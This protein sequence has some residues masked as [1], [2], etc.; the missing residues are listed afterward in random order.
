MQ[1]RLQALKTALRGRGAQLEPC[2]DIHMVAHMQWVDARIPIL[3]VFCK[4]TCKYGLFTVLACSSMLLETTCNVARAIQQH[5]RT[6]KRRANLASEIERT[7][8]YKSV[9]KLVGSSKLFF[10]PNVWDLICFE[11]ST[12][13]VLKVARLQNSV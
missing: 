6:K 1:R 11:S 7:Q 2:A 5:T 8:K 9:Q 13:H 3:A 12:A 4:F 10:S